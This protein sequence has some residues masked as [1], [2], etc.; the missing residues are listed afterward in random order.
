MK[1]IR[2]AGK[3]Q[4]GTIL[5]RRGQFEPEAT[6]LESDVFLNC[7]E[8]FTEVNFG[9]IAI[10]RCCFSLNFCKFSEMLPVSVMLELSDPLDP[11][12]CSQ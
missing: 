7:V 8:F 5:S 11:H 2:G 4:G 12:L 10:V 9:G 6:S 1:T 3:K